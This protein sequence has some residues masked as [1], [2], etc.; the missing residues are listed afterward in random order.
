M[1]EMLVHVLIQ[2]AITFEILKSYRGFCIFLLLKDY[3][4][5]LCRLE[6]SAS[7]QVFTISFYM[8]AIS[9]HRSM[10]INTVQ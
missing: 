6:V 2:T 7:F 3:T 5:R 4:L 1:S 8:K 9:S 10:A